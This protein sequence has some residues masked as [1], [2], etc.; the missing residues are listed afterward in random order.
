MK[1]KFITSL[2][3][4]LIAA[5]VLFHF[6]SQLGILVLPLFVSLVLIVTLWLYRLMEDNDFSDK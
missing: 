3:I 6:K 1:T 5:A 4:T 2:I